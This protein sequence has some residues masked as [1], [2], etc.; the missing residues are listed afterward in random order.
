MNASDRNEVRDLFLTTLREFLGSRAPD[1]IDE[2]TDPIKDIGLDSADGVDFACT[3]SD[4]FG[5]KIPDNVNPFVDDKRH[6]SRS[7]GDTINLVFA[8][9]NKGDS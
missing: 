5:F 8:L 4:K 2:T 7:I 3:L 1:K 6:C 9:A